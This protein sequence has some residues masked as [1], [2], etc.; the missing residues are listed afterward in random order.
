MF[1][2]A[3]HYTDLQQPGT[4]SYSISTRD[5]DARPTCVSVAGQAHYLVVLP[6]RIV[7]SL[8]GELR[9][10]L[11]VDPTVCCKQYLVQYKIHNGLILMFNV[12]SCVLT[13]L[14][15]ASR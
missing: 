6:D 11:A 14:T 13:R 10:L 5:S 8:L 7:Q 2:E 12:L 4:L 1:M 9:G 15:Q 3:G